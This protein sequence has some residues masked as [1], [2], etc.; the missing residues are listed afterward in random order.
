VEEGFLHPNVDPNRPEWIVPGDEREPV[1]SPGYVVSFA[2]FHKRG[3][4]MPADK[5][6]RWIIH[7]YKLELQNLNPN[8]I[9]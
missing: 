1:C 6:I 9:Q 7:H 2:R 5:F 3:F 4:G 8:S